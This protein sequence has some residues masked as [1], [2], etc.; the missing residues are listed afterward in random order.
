MELKVQ[1]V[2]IHVPYKP[3]GCQLSMINR[4]C[5]AYIL[6]MSGYEWYEEFVEHDSAGIAS[7]AE[8]RCTC[9]A[10]EALPERPPRIFFGTRTHK[11]IS[12]VIRELRKTKYANTRMCILS[13]RTHT[14][15]NP[16]VRRQSNINDACANLTRVCSLFSALTRLSYQMGTCP[17]DQPKRRSDLTKCMED[18]HRSGPWD[19]EEYVERLSK[20]AS[21]LEGSIIIIDEAHNLEDAARDAT[22]CTLLEKDILTATEDLHKLIRLRPP[23]KEN[24]QPLLNLLG[25]LHRVMDITRSRLV[26]AG[27]SANSSHVW[28]GSEIEGLLQTVGLGED[29]FR[30]IRSCYQKLISKIPTSNGPSQQSFSPYLE[31]PTSGTI[32]LF[33]YIFTLL[34][35]LYGEEGHHM[36]DY[37]AVLTEVIDYERTHGGDNGVN[38]LEH[39]SP[40]RWLS[41]VTKSGSKSRLLESRTLSLNFWCL[42]PAVCMSSLASCAHSLILASGTLAPLDALAA[43]LGLE[44]PV[45]LEA[46]HVV[47][48]DRVFA[49][50]IARGPGGSRLLANYTNQNSFAF[51]DDI[52]SLIVGACRLVPGGVLCFFPSY[53][54]L[55]K[56]VQRW[57]LTGMLD[58]LAK[59]KH[60]LQEPRTSSDFSAWM[61][62]FYEAIDATRPSAGHS[63]RSLQDLGL[64]TQTGAVALAVYRGKVSEGLDFAD[65]YA[66]LIVS[67][68]IPFPA[69]KNPQVSCPRLLV[70]L[71]SLLVISLL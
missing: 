62:E 61:S 67:V 9:G 15:I 8:K 50:S 32:R 6:V 49:A 14:C 70:I 64:P 20:V 40:A 7:F 51:Q 5:L 47:S 41:K 28:T 68:G 18:L 10:Q 38:G 45:R 13:S 39:N 25:S 46:N 44:F 58:K 1:G 71:L 36:A 57:E 56:L 37:R 31:T 21:D 33:D 24:T 59:V 4:V 3:Y 27:D 30:S 11:Q 2:K 43:E 42:N 69:F 22:S 19:L 26:S 29:K 65:D 53:G 52:G 63:P 48:A 66:R 60:I 23:E 55:D 17:Y 34:G 16:D 54:L 12:Q 35:F